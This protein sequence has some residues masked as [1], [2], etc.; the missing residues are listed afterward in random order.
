[1]RPCKYC[2]DPASGLRGATVCS[3]CGYKSRQVKTPRVGRRNNEQRLK[4]ESMYLSGMTM[5]YIADSIGISRQRVSQLVYDMGIK[6]RPPGTP[7]TNLD[8]VQIMNMRAMGMTYKSIAE[9]TKVSAATVFNRVK[10]SLTA[11]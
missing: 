9:V 1:M 4:I 8:I 5:Q 3:K 6:S 10:D 11:T 7:A 2:G